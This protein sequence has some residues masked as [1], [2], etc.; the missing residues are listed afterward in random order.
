M[1][2]HIHKHVNKPWS[3]S[4]LNQ[5]ILVL[6][7]FGLLFRSIV[8]FWLPA[9]F[10][11]AYYYIYTQHL[12]WS[13]FDHPPLV[14]F[15]T[16]LG[17]W[18]TG[19]VSQFTIRLGSLIAYTATLYF[20]FRATTHLFSVRAGLLTLAIASLAPIF[21][22]VFGTFTLP[23]VPLMFFWSLTLW[24]A[25][26]EFF[27]ETGFEYRPTYRLAVLG[28]LVGCACLGKYHGFLLGFGLVGF[29]FTSRQHRIALVSPWTLLS[30]ILFIITFSPVLYWN[31]QHDWVSFRFQGHRGV[32]DRSYS[33]PNALKAALLSAVYLFP[34]FGLPLWWTSLRSSFVTLKSWFSQPRLPVI[35]FVI[36]LS[37]PVVFIF[38][39]IGGYQQI[40][41]SWTM[42]GFL[43]A[44]PLL[45]WRAS[46]WEE[47]HPKA[48]K[49]WLVGSAISILSL[50]LILL[51]HITAGIAQKPGNYAIFGG[52][53]APQDDASI[54]LVDVLQLRRELAKSPQLLAALKET[55]FVF[56]N[57]FHLSGHI[58]MAITP[59]SPV[60][61]TCF[62]KRDLRGFAFWS[63]A[64][65]WVGKD[66]L[67]ITSNLFQTRENS[68]AE[69][70]PYFQQFTKLGEVP[71]RR[72]DVVVD[73]FHIFQGTNLLKP[74]PRPP[75]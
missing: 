8:A 21:Q 75:M 74:Y 14:A 70:V 48:V 35:P 56:S 69:Y 10:D 68:A 61:V 29:C 47:R 43:A 60:P 67:Y 23:D 49:R 58:A 55:D 34:T 4:K 30:L 46:L 5:T 33:I 44:T 16:G 54:Q 25:A 31:W 39:F 9:G 50:M 37:M 38:T 13:Y 40:L 42:P 20:L 12:D 7:G 26:C 51:L 53:L 15:T 27:P 73:T 59:L 18:L 45:G 11:E 62:D 19:F 57:R 6:L 24:V 17:V 72:G 36:W 66:A 65:Q 28:F 3:I 1:N 71:L 32:P 64:E 2:Q 22:L 41:P 52:F 63:T